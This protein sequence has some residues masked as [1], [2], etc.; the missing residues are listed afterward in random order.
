MGQPKFKHKEEEAFTV[1]KTGDQFRQ[2]GKQLNDF[3]EFII[4]YLYIYFFC[5]W[6]LSMQKFS[7]RE[8]I[9]RHSNDNTGSLIHW[10]TRELHYSF[11]KIFLLK[12]N[13]PKKTPQS[14]K[15]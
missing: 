12:Y 1:H 4:L 3:T 5:G 13:M 2:E 8:S 9:P 7:G 10:A 6:T 15:T 14:V 11:L